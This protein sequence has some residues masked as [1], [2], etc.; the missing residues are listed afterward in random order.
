MMN[1]NT[2]KSPVIVGQV[3]PDPFETALDALRSVG[4][5]FE[6]VGDFSGVEPGPHMFERA[7]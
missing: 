4:V 1:T 2:P 7:A 6:V 5:G 3:S